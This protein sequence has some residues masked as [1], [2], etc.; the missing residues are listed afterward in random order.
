MDGGRLLLP[1]SGS[2]AAVEAAEVTRGHPRLTPLSHPS[3]ATALLS[4]RFLGG[5]EQPHL[6]LAG[7]IF[8]CGATEK[9]RE[10]RGCA[11]PPK[12]ASSITTGSV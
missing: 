7:F 2:E 3:H 10:I 8:S 6:N 9:K 1:Q 12:N 5:D 11:A 4:T